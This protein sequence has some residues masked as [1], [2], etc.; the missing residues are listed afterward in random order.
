[1]RFSSYF[2]HTVR[3]DPS[4]A[5]IISHK[6]MIRA[7]MIRKLAAGIYNYLPLG[8]RSIRKVENIVR[9][10]MNRA[11]AIELLMPT[12]LPAEPWTESGRWDY[13]G[14]ELLRFKDRTERDFCLGPTHEEIITDIVRKEVRSYKQLPVNFY[15]IQT[16]FRDE[17]RPRFGVMR[18]REFIMKD[19]Y[20]FDVS[21]DQADHSYQAM[22]DTYVRIFERCGLEFSVVAA[23]SGNI[24]GSFSHEFMVTADTGEDVIMSSTKADYVANLE[25][26]KIGVSEEEREG[27]RSTS[28]LDKISEIH[29]PGLKTIEDVAQLLKVKPDKLIKTLIVNTETKPIV[30]LVRGD[31]ELSLTKLRNFLG[32]DVIE[33]ADAQ[34]ISEVSGGPLGFSG[35]VGLKRKDVKLI[36]DKSIRNMTN[37]VTG[38]NKADY[39][40]IGVNP[41]RD[42]EADFYEDIRVA[43]EGDPCPISEDGVLKESRGIEVGHVFKLGTKYSEALGATYVDESGA[44]KHLVMGCYGIGIGRTVAAAIEQNNDEYGIKFP[45]P[46]A[47]FEVSILPINIKQQEVKD[48]AEKIYS[49]LISNGVDVLIDD[50]QET[51][52]VKFK[53]SDLLGIPIQITIGRRSLQEG[54]VEI[55]K[56]NSGERKTLAL[57]DLQ[58]EIAALLAEEKVC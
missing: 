31:A 50:R 23:D 33:F 27:T 55:K 28:G 49:E 24:G 58:G 37:A 30:A 14:K 22:Y 4:D 57:E 25:L 56:R 38:A 45:L 47:P 36:A 13:Y 29:T 21:D 2:I 41:G 43:R 1:M 26:A 10:E 15:Q 7:G 16:K 35:P 44:E 42:F 3:E 48:T 20:S 6:L 39:H 19:A 5:E 12:V 9:E 40:I 11:G 46:L 18:A 32:C 8:L 17:I 34:T 53:D 51:A 52:G 54:K